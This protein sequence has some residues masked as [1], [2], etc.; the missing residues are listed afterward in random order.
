MLI[1]ELLDQLEHIPMVDQ[2]YDNHVQQVIHELLQQW[3]H[4]ILANSLLLDRLHEQ[5]D[6]MRIIDLLLI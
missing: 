6:Q 4:E 3:L 5:I 2:I 1:I